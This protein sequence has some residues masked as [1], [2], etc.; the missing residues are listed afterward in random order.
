[1]PEWL[2][3]VGY[4]GMANWPCKSSN[5]QLNFNG[6]SAKFVNGKLEVLKYQTGEGYNI[7]FICLHC[8]EMG[9]NDFKG[10]FKEN[11]VDNKDE[12]IIF[13]HQ[14]DENPGVKRETL[15]SLQSAYEKLRFRFFKG[16]GPCELQNYPFCVITRLT[17][18]SSCNTK[19]NN[20][21]CKR[22][23]SSLPPSWNELKA[24][25]VDLASESTHYKFVI[26]SLFFDLAIQCDEGEIHN[27]NLKAQLEECLP[28][29]EF[30]LKGEEE[31]NPSLN[32]SLPQGLALLP[33]L[34][35]TG[36]EAEAE[37]IS[38][39]YKTLN[40]NITSQDFLKWLKE[41]NDILDN[42]RIEVSEGKSNE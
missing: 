15:E 6:C 42:I 22:P 1:M 34:K 40:D 3:L 31:N 35:L 24:N 23:N 9:E 21:S 16:A 33:V 5:G 27:E 8:E 25:S 4:T 32:I 41:L 29:L 28:K 26:N 12:I 19:R 7:L 10:V 38:E 36:K 11:G 13:S 14:K 37:K 17:S 20:N 39:H 18:S 30:I 2:V